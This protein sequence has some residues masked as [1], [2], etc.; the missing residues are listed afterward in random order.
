MF[1]VAAGPAGKVEVAHR[2]LFPHSPCIITQPLRLV[3]INLRS[4]TRM[5]ADPWADVPSPSKTAT[6]TKRRTPSPSPP[7]G[8]DA[9]DLPTSPDSPP[10]K[11]A[12]LELTTAS[13]PHVETSPDTFDDFDEF[14]DD[15]RAGP[16]QTVDDDDAFGDFDDFQ[17]GGFEDTAEQPESEPEPMPI[18]G[19]SWVS[20]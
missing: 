18:A 17:E 13:S 3:S 14:D 16:S 4:R 2:R 12:E 11:D 19:P 6:P 20:L 5:D 10:A 15:P 1:K 7:D 9:P 8:V